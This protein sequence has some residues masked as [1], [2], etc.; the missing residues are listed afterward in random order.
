MKTGRLEAF[1]DG[2]LAIIITIMV[3]QMRLPVGSNFEALYSTLPTFMNYLGSFIYV[4]IYWNNHHH[5]FQATNKVSGQVLWSNLNLL[6]WLSLLPFATAWM[7]ENNF[8]KQPVAFYGFIL[9]MV[10]IAYKI[11][12]YFI[13]KSEGKQSKI[14]KAIG[15]DYKGTVSILLYVLAIGVSFLL[16]LLSNIVY[17]MVALVWLIPDKRIVKSL[18]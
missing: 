9:L 17:F 13:V 2:V 15:R 10:A 11:L 4:G 1:S 6:F 14:S 7:G 5:L 8:E 12:T 16:P 18:N 3:L